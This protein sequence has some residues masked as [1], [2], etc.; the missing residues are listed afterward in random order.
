MARRKI[1]VNPFDAATVVGLRLASL[2]MLAVE[3][4]PGRIAEAQ[5]M[6]LEKPVAALEG[7]VAVQQT[8]LKMMFAPPWLWPTPSAAAHQLARAAATPAAR[9][10]R[11]NAKRL[12]SR[13]G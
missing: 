8:F 11:A 1:P 13:K 10:V 12:S 2:G 6:V 7:M 5:R 3:P 9:R 4:T